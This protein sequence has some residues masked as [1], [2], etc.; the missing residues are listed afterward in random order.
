MGSEQCNVHKAAVHY[1]PRYELCLPFL[2]TKKT[3]SVLFLLPFIFA[4]ELLSLAQL[5][6]SLLGNGS[7][8]AVLPSPTPAPPPST[9]SS[10]NSS[11]SSSSSSSDGGSAVE[12][13]IESM[14]GAAFQLLRQQGGSTGNDDGEG[15]AGRVMVQ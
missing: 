14:I 7:I 8:A 3:S 2:T 10:N 13:A 6:F 11:S 5:L 1:A 15:T 12:E 9:G 4:D